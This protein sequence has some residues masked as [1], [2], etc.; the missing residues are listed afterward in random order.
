MNKKHLIFKFVFLPIF[1]FLY[2]FKVIS[3]IFTN[4]KFIDTFYIDINGFNLDF[5]NYDFLNSLNVD[6][7]IQLFFL[8]LFISS[9][10]FNVTLIIHYVI[11]FFER[12]FFKVNFEFYFK[13]IH[14][15]MSY[16]SGFIVFISVL[17]DYL[18]IYNIIE[19]ADALNN[20]ILLKGYPI[21]ILIFFIISFNNI[22]YS[23]IFFEGRIK[24]Y[25]KKNISFSFILNSTCF[26]IFLLSILNI[27]FIILFILCLIF[28]VIF[29]KLK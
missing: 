24:V 8:M 13:L 10:V 1:V 12:L 15:I 5:L 23:F 19:E 2:Y 4:I 17:K 25:D 22:I 21:F 28:K 7:I 27:H 3:F 11:I 14:H 6:V 16:I 18:Y 20:S 9:I 26:S 29:E